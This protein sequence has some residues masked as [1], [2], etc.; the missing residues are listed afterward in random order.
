MS[1]PLLSLLAVLALFAVP[2]LS[3]GPLSHYYF[4]CSALQNVSLPFNTNCMC[5]QPPAPD[6]AKTAASSFSLSLAQNL[7]MLTAYPPIDVLT[8]LRGSDLPDGM[9]NGHFFTG[10]QCPLNAN[11]LHDPVFAGYMIQYAVAANDPDLF[12][13]AVGYASHVVSDV[14]GFAAFDTSHPGYLGNASQPIDWTT[15]WIQMLAVDSLIAQELLTC[16]PDLPTTPAT[17]AENTFISQSTQ[18]YN[19]VNPQFPTFPPTD[20]AACTQPWAA[21]VNTRNDLSFSQAPTQTLDTLVYFDPYGAV[22]P[23]Q[24]TVN[25]KAAISC[26]V[27]GVQ[28]YLENLLF[29]SAGVTPMQALTTTLQQVQGLFSAGMCGGPSL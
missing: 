8:T 4:I 6:S 21:A 15:K 18:K 7:Q 23:E 10:T 29:V 28:F 20:I 13:L 9:W 19:A 16:T 25:A 5:Y 11:H 3:W 1:Q 27:L 22:T 2:A 14:V 26:A 17:L 24:A 12:S